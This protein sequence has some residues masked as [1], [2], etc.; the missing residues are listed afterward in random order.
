MSA[1]MVPRK[2]AIS[3]GGGHLPNFQ[4]EAQGE[5]RGGHRSAELPLLL[6]GSERLRAMVLRGHFGATQAALI[7]TT[8]GEL[9]AREGQSARR[10]GLGAGD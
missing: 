3:N 9:H 5:A 8:A 4:Q 6:R 7:S 2:C 10:V 1:A